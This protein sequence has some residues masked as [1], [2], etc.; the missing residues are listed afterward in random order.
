MKKIFKYLC[1]CLPVLALAVGCNEAEEDY[2]TQ[3]QPDTNK[4]GKVTLLASIENAATRASM[5]ATGE[6]RWLRG[7][8]IGVLCEDGSVVNFT[9]DGT[10][11]TRRALFTADIA[12]KTVGEYAFYPSSALLYGGNLSYTLPQTILP[13]ASGECP[14]MAAQITEN[15][16]IEFKQLLAFVVAEIKDVNPM[17]T[18]IVISSNNNLSGD[19]VA[20][21]PAA[22]ESGIAATAGDATIT[23]DTTNLSGQVVTVYFAVP[24]GDYTH[25]TAVA[26]DELGVNLGEAALI[27]GSV[28]AARGGL[29]TCKATMPYYEP[30]F[31]PVDG[32]WGAGTPGGKIDENPYN[33]EL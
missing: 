8:A 19:V 29:I 27:S 14:L 15:N 20:A 13:A 28:N 7:D 31:V 10:G 16:Q 30:T 17:T 24:V 33:G 23:I 2:S 26:Y 18:R 32:D 21:L 5:V 12:D 11:D 3:F 25:L 6:A 22:L 4:S 1:F 9:L